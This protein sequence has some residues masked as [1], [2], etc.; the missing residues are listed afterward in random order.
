[1]RDTETCTIYKIAKIVQFH[2]YNG[3]QNFECD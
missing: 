2:L 3:M 1:M